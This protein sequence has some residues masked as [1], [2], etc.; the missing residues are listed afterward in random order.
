[1]CIQDFE[2][3][4]AHQLGSVGFIADISLGAVRTAPAFSFGCESDGVGLFHP[5]FDA[6]FIAAQT[7]L[8][9][10]CGEFAEIKRRVMGLFPDTQKLDGNPKKKCC[11]NLLLLVP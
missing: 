1:M 2:V 9:F 7:R 6:D 10:N 4:Q 11:E 3:G 8:T 5:L